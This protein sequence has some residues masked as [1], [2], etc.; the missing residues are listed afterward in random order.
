MLAWVAGLG[1][2][3][4]FWPGIMVWDSG[5]QYAQALSGQFDDW[6]PPLMGWIWRLFFPLMA[7]PV[8]MLVL[9][10]VLYGAGLGFLAHRAWRHGHG[11]QAAWLAA[12]AL[13][14]PTLLLM[15]TIIKDSLMAAM[16]LAAFATL[17]HFRDS[18]N[19]L[20][21]ATGIVL[22]LIASCLRFNAF[23]AGIP[24]VLLALPDRRA[25]HRGRAALAMAGAA[26][27]L[28]LAMPMANRLLRAQHSGVELSL[29]IFD[30][31]GITAH[32]GGNVFP[33][34]A[35]IDPVSVNDDCYIAE[36]WDS[37][38]W[39]V[40]PTCPMDFKTV[41]AAFAAQ[42]INPGLFWIR[43]IVIHPVAYATHRLS[44]WNIAS[45][46]LVSETTD[47]WITSASDPNEWDFRVAPNLANRLVSTA[48]RALNATPFGW[49]CWWLAFGFGL[50]TLGCRL[51]L[52]RLLV[53]LAGSA[54]LYAL[55][56]VPLSVASELRYY[57]WP[58]MATLIATVLFVG[59]WRETPVALRPGR[60][61]QA[62]AA[63][64]LAVIT[65][66]GLGWRWLG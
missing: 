38:S 1:L 65:V 28:L 61:Q 26:G 2:S 22:I 64:P 47:R 20:S 21:R 5:H 51:A 23:L 53:A 57:C 62:L 55:G 37:Y 27:L 24:L 15:A 34:M 11:Q 40:D 63:A 3:L 12:T 42:H 36:R 54:F 50:V 6:H 48:V 56:Y 43:A 31:G 41:R 18:G 39:W 9:Q 30:L 60:M 29:V 4:S 59:R 46:F 7:G 52:P 10:L 19:R 33:P 16:L 35:I 14:P 8:P 49:P 25:A 58:F 45:Q 13:F 66:L 44:H 32:G 17:C